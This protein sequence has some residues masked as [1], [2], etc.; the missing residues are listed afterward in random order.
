MNRSD[1][2]LV[3]VR[4][5][6]EFASGHLQGAR[7]I[8]FRSPSFLDEATRTLDPSRPVYLYCRS[9]NRSGQAAEL[10]RGKGYQVADLKGGVVEWSANGQEIVR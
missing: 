2:Q 10:L 5:A 3:D 1:V 6:E 7:L 4:T 8:D 9:G